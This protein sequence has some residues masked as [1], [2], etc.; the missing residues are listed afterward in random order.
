VA[1]AGRVDLNADLGETVEPA[2]GTDDSLGG[3]VE[4]LL[5]LVTT[6]HIACGFHAGGPR[7]M[8]R[9]VAAA[10]AAG[11][12]VGA[13]PSYPDPEGFGRRPMDRPAR[14]VADDVIR[15]LEALGS[16]ALAEGAQVRSVK[17]HG[18][19]YHRLATDEECAVAVAEALRDHDPDLVLVAPAGAPTRAAMVGCGVSVVAEGFCDRAYLADGSLAPRSQP[20]SVLVDPTSAGMRAVAM[21]LGREVEAI[22][23]SAVVLE[24]DTLCVHGDTPGAVSVA[25]AVRRAL[26]G[27]GVSVAPYAA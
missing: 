6:T 20:G 25:D 19:L 5:A 16:A 22:D 7:V 24:C 27:A 21:A 10:V 23:G 17:P 4:P 12:V 3:T 26:L 1:E 15:Q 9:T 14:L 8:R 13:H 11:V 18:A 2:A